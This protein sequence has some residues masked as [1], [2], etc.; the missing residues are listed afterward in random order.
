MRRYETRDIFRIDSDALIEMT[1]LYIQQNLL[2]KIVSPFFDCFEMN[3][4]QTNKS[5]DFINLLF[6]S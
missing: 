1:W 4:W 3:I 6:V 2:D 5:H